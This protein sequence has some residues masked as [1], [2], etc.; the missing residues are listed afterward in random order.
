[1]GLSIGSGGLQQAL[2]NNNSKANDRVKQATERLSTG[3]RINRGRDDPAG[4]IGAEQLRG[5]LIEIQAR[6]SSANAERG[7][8]RVQESGRKNA[9]SVLQNLRGELLGVSGSLSSPEQL[10]A[11]QQQ[12][13]SAIDSLERLSATTG[14]SLPTELQTLREGGTAEITGGDTAAAVAVLDEQLATIVQASAAAGAYERYTL[15]V[16]QRIAED[17]AVVTAEALSQQ[18]DADFAEETSNL[19]KGQILEEASLKTM[20]LAQKL[21]A[22]GIGLLFD[23]LAG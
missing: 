12:V 8:L 16:D 21:R 15:D 17:Q 7:Q 6:A 22:E 1:M 19:I 13:D 9:T 11:T 2:L 20:V 5:D 18:E 10:A 23:S 4:L 3:K 14:F